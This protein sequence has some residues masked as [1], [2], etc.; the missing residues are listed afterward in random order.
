METYKSM[1]D[2]R[3]DY[4]PMQGRTLPPGRPNCELDDIC[5][6]IGSLVATVREVEQRLDRN[7]DALFGSQPQCAGAADERL[8]RDGIVGGIV[9]RLDDLECAMRD[10]QAAAARN[11]IAA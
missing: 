7:A 10:L 4:P 3:P 11:C 2:Q 6:R 8:R 1:L 5:G 9:D